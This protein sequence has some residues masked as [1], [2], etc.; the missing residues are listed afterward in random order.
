LRK[1]LE[2]VVRGREEKI[3]LLEVANEA[4]QNGFP[5]EEGISELREFARY[6]N[7]RSEVLVAITSNHGVEEGFAKTYAGSEADLATWHF[8]RDRS[9]AGG[10]GPVIDCWDFAMKPGFP[11]VIS[12][13][14]IGPGAS[15]ASERE[16]IRLVM[17]A[18]FGY[19]AKLPSYVF[20][21]EAG[22]FGRSRFEETPGIDSFG[23]LLTLL[24][25][26]L[27][28]W[29]R[30]DG[31]GAD[32]PL[33]VLAGGHID[34][35]W[36]EVKTASDGCLMNAG[37]RKG[38]R[39]VCVPIGIKPAGLQIEART[40]V[41]FTVYHPMSGEVLKSASLKAGERIRLPMGPGALIIK[42]E[43]NGEAREGSGE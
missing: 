5:G 10:W 4:W 21:S 39:F 9:V 1:L 31:K 34:Q 12:N 13:E 15:V 25:P 33:R 43:I 19:V 38:N 7:A 8:S 2:K 22:V 23:A 40:G 6:L 29:R 27:P 32:A 3:M 14:P 16:P 24:P 42:G 11:P 20:H 28:N 18:A 17:A 30:N 37:S 35:Y 26:D 36:P 41:R